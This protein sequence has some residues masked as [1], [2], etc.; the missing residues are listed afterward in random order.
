MVQRVV[1][2]RMKADKEYATALQGIGQLASRF[3]TDAQLSH[4]QS[5]LLKVRVI[6]LTH[7]EQ[8]KKKKKIFPRGNNPLVYHQ[9]GNTNFFIF[10]TNQSNL[11]FSV[12]KIK[13]EHL[14][15]L[16]KLKSC[17]FAPRIV[18]FNLCICCQYEDSQIISPKIIPVSHHNLLWQ[19][20]AHFLQKF[21]LFL[22]VHNI[23]FLENLIKNYC[24]RMHC[25]AEWVKPTAHQC[26]SI[27]VRYNATI[28][29]ISSSQNQIAYLICI[30]LKKLNL[31][32]LYFAL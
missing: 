21:F 5:P 16:S 18:I 24:I 10:I 6:L 15:I 28:C 29:W 8:K 4:N 19:M 22:L 11:M 23:E 27:P 1:Q 32:W 17:Q 7:S 26:D 31:F 30:K 9:I 20:R 3:D 14:A 12:N 2:H 13:Y 25:K